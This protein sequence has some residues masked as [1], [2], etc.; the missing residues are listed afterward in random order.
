MT[1]SAPS[2]SSQPPSG[3][4]CSL[5]PPAPRKTS[6]R[7]HRHAARYRRASCSF[8]A[9]AVIVPSAPFLTERLPCAPQKLCLLVPGNIRLQ[10]S[11]RIESDS[12]GRYQ[13]LREQQFITGTAPRGLM[14]ASRWRREPRP[15][16]E[17]PRTL[18]KAHNHALAVLPIHPNADSVSRPA[19]RRDRLVI[20]SLPSRR[21]VLGALAR[22][23]AAG[24]TSPERGAPRASCEKRL[25]TQGSGRGGRARRGAL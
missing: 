21:P 16:K 5:F 23:L 19:P 10:S 22:S 18:R 9:T 20:G 13:S 17:P 8:V 1:N 24:D 6:P 3:V 7:N 25:Q 14:A 11:L 12:P 2:L 4:S 15:L